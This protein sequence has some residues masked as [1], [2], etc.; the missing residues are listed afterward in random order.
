M[1]VKTSAKVRQ[2]VLD[3][4][5]RAASG[6]ITDDDDLI[7]IGVVDSLSLLEIVSALQD[8]FGIAIPDADLVPRHFV[9]LAAVRNYLATRGVE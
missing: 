8:E 5:A 9:S 3:R 7:E 6:P 4:A 1:N 2:L